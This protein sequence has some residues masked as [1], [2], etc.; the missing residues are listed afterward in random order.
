MLRGPSLNPGWFGHPATTTMYV[1]A[2]VNAAV[3]LVGKML[4]WFTSVKDF[5][6]AAFVD[7][8][9]I[10]LPGRVVMAIFGSCS[11]WLTHRL[12]RELFGK[13]AWISAIF[14]AFSP[15][16]IWWGQVIR[17]D[18]MA[19]VFLQLSLLAVLRYY[20]APSR[21]DF[22]V[23]GGWLGVAVATK[24]PFAL[25]ALSMAAAIIGH[26][27]QGEAYLVSLGKLAAKL[28]AFGLLV[29]G[30]LLL[31]SPYI[32]LAHDT[33]LRNLS[34]ESQLH[35]LGA[36]GGTA[37][38]NAWWYVSGP[39]SRSFGL[40]GLVLAVA[41]CF[42]MQSVKEARIIINP[43]LLSFALVLCSQNLVWERW[44]LPLLPFLAM[45]AG[46]AITRLSD[47]LED[48]YP[49]S[50]K[51]ALPTVVLLSIVPLIWADIGQAR[52]RMNDT[53]QRASAWAIAH[54]PAGSSVMIEHFG[55][56]LYSRPWRVLF[57]LGN[58]GCVD[59]KSVLKG[60]IAYSAIEDAREGKSNVDYG[61]MPNRLAQTCAADYAI[62]TQYDRYVSERGEFP[63]EYLAYQN[64]LK[65][66]EGEIVFRPFDSHSSGPVVRI[67]KMRH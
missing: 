9:Y 6:S 54:I 20:R 24:W 2:L 27:K 1:L 26:R 29:T 41:G 37:W 22:M 25:G 67:V 30:A 42:L 3:F 21:R 28:A 63:Q 46:L 53:R 61:T 56:D 58:L 51:I 45:S 19:T 7:P 10:I 8:S 34:G 15:V 62:L 55:F 49:S 14:V 38:Q 36:T 64:I 5:A 39:L 47:F 17:S 31:C 11:V 52:A 40:A 35:H 44:V 13:G 33:V 50:R 32:A 16:V 23:A 57:P 65:K 60:Q 12:A 18:V 66:S 59:A 4:G 48:K 43:L